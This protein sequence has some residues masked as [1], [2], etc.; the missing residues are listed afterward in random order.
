MRDFWNSYVVQT[1]V[2]VYSYV[3]G[4]NYTMPKLS[5]VC[6]YVC[7]RVCVCVVLV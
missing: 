2:F 5:D 3:Q 1:Q 7:L 6:V 4:V